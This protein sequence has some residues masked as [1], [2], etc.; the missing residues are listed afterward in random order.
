MKK[1]YILTRA[2]IHTGRIL[3]WAKDSS[4]AI[5][6]ANGR[7]NEDWVILRV[8]EDNDLPQILCYKE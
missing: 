6:I 5:R 4:E 8:V 2:C 1:V 7:T 3:V